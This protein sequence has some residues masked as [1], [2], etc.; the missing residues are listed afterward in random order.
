MSKWGN[1]CALSAENAIILTFSDN[2][3]CSH[4]S[5][6]HREKKVN[7][8]ESTGET[9]I[10]PGSLGACGGDQYSFGH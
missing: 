9:E 1:V 3:K 5:L 6:Y 7:Y 4:R 10:A 8:D 2:L